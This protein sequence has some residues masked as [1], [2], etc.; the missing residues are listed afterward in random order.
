MWR[1]TVRGG[2]VPGGVVRRHR[3][4]AWPGRGTGAAPCAH[5]FRPELCPGHCRKAVEPR[6]VLGPSA[7]VDAH[8]LLHALHKVGIAPHV[9]RNKAGAG[10]NRDGRARTRG[11]LAHRTAVGG[12]VGGASTRE[13][14]AGVS[15]K[16]RPLPRRRA[17]MPRRKGHGRLA[18]PRRCRALASP[19][20]P[21]ALPR[22]VHRS[23]RTF[24]SKP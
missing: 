4:A 13:Q 18:R 5:R 22:R 11:P 1:G 8:D 10:L 9:L 24:P 23:G 6:P 12:R 21:Q 3:D 16:G 7:L 20:T 2:R 19:L 17:G 15:F 14:A